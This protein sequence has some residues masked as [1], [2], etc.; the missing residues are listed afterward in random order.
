MNENH[1]SAPGTS[2]TVSLAADDEFEA[3]MSELTLEAG[4]QAELA[5]TAREQVL[6][7]H[8]HKFWGLEAQAQQGRRM[9]EVRREI[10]ESSET[11]TPVRPVG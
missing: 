3:L 2:H 11:T 5:A 7:D 4:G 9:R 6:M 1:Y 8:Q 10:M